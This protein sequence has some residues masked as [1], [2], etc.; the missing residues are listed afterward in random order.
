M[1][2]EQNNFKQKHLPWW[3]NQPRPFR[4]QVTENLFNWLTITKYTLISAFMNKFFTENYLNFEAFFRSAP[5][6]T[7]TTA[8][9][10]RTHESRRRLFQ[11][12]NLRALT[13]KIVILILKS[14]NVLNFMLNIFFK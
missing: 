11:V 5:S 13:T 1:P 10:Q 8:T 12:S 7:A 3:L 9:Q 6:D 4:F 2:G 14:Q